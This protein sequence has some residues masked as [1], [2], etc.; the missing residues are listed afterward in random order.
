MEPMI[1]YL[2]DVQIRGTAAQAVGELY[3]GMSLAAI[4]WRY[5]IVDNICKVAEVCKQSTAE[6]E[7]WP[8]K[9][10]AKPLGS[11]VGSDVAHC[12]QS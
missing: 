6:S 8:S 9:L 7:G 11:L 12:S 2:Q 10:E 4:G 5:S 3:H 1:G